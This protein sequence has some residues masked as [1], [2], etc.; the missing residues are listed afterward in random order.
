MEAARRPTISRSFTTRRLKTISCSAVACAEATSWP[1]AVAVEYDRRLDPK[2][3][4][5][6]DAASVH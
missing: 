4:L 2:N 1:G 6:I 3:A 5:I